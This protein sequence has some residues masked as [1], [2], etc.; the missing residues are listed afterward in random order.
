MATAMA[1]SLEIAMAMKSKHYANRLCFVL[2][3][4]NPFVLLES[5]KV[6]NQ[7]FKAHI[8]WKRSVKVI[9]FF[10]T[11]AKACELPNKNAIS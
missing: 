2:H 6:V 11:K 4:F 10:V 9:M 3:E 8:D 7:K 5:P 1:I